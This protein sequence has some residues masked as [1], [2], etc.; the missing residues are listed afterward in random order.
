MK[1]EHVRGSSALSPKGPSASDNSSA[2]SKP[3]GATVKRQPS[4]PVA[5]GPSF[6][7]TQRPILVSPQ[8]TGGETP[9]GAPG[10]GS[11]SSRRQRASERHTDAGLKSEGNI[12]EKSPRK[13]RRKS[14]LS[15]RNNND[16]KP[17][18]SEDVIPET[19]IDG[20]EIKVVTITKG[21]DPLDVTI[22]GGTGSPWDGVIVVSRVWEGGAI[23]KNG[24]IKTGDQLLMVEGVSLNGISLAEAQSAIK[25]AMRSAKDSI[26][27]VV[28]VAEE[29]RSELKL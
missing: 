15:P 12:P 11:D 24:A 10:H 29:N 17:A 28:A 3:A 18:T 25:S 14:T 19:N 7:S 9:R 1:T 26:S 23:D 6:S 22:E 8:A 20:R 16:G 21:E 4:I 13:A 27:F 2:P 5:Q